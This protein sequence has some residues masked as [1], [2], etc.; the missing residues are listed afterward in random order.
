[1]AKRKL[2]KRII[3]GAI[4][5]GVTALMNKDV[6]KY[7]KKKISKAK[8]RTSLMVKNPSEM[9]RSTRTRLTNLSDAISEQTTKTINTLDQIED[10]LDQFTKR[11]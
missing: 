9:V 5:G 11:K 4:A 1:M 2:I 10:T 3:I 7:T 6:R 8:D